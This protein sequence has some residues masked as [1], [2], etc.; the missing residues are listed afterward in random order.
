MS[1]FRK[2]RR[3]YI[4]AVWFAAAVQLQLFFAPELHHHALR[5]LEETAHAASSRAAMWPLPPPE[6]PCPACRIVRENSVSTAQNV[7]PAEPVRLSQL[8]A[9]PAG[10]RLFSVCFSQSSGRDPPFFS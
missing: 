1:A 2:H 7:Q 3:I 9:R 5:F 8:L 4:A 10:P 6:A